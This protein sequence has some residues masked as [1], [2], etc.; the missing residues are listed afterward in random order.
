[1][2]NIKSLS[3]VWNVV[4]Q[5]MSKMPTNNS[6]WSTFRRLSLGAVVYFM[7]Q[8][9]S[10]RQLRNESYKSGGP[11]KYNK[12]NCQAKDYEHLCERF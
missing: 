3:D 6:V 12:R 8:Q 2:R 9:R 1:M 7:R 11:M 5:E 4:F 10:A